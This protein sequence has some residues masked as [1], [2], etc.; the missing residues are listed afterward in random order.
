MDSRIYRV[1]GRKISGSVKGIIAQKLVFAGIRTD[2][3]IWLGMRLLA[4]LLVGLA[5]A[6]APWALF[7]YVIDTTP[8]TTTQAEIIQLMVDSVL[9]FIVS[10][11]LIG[12]LFY[13]NLYYIIDDRTKRVESVLPDYLFILSANLR[14]GMSSFNAFR[15]AA[16]PHFGPLKEE[17]DIVASKAAA[18]GSLSSALIELSQRIDSDALKRT[19]TFF[20]KGIKAGGK[21]AE[22]IEVS[23]DEMRK[24]SDLKKEM[25]IQTKSYMVFIVFIIVFLIPLLLSISS[26]FLTNMIDMRNDQA[27]VFKG[28]EVKMLA[29]LQKE[30]TITP[31]FIDV[32]AAFT[33]ITV[34]LLVS[35]FIGVIGEGKYLYGFKYYPMVLVISMMMYVAFRFMVSSV[36]SVLT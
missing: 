17:V 9:L 35:L 26:Q 19:I 16:L 28:T 31:E 30:I 7:K 5:M 23:A 33:L 18:G 1:L 8:E 12:F 36:L 25:Q 6:I 20:E 22:L 32:V 15:L 14:A 11:S 4:M 2:P 24:V 13:M 10:S 3:D 21:M 29:I 27:M 34:T